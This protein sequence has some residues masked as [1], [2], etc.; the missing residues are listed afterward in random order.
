MSTPTGFSDSEWPLSD[1]DTSSFASLE[2]LS[3]PEE[4]TGDDSSYVESSKKRKRATTP[5]DLAQDGHA[6][7]KKLRQTKARQ[8]P[9]IPRRQD[10]FFGHLN[11]NIRDRIYAHLVFDPLERPHRTPVCIDGHAFAKT[12][13][14]ARKEL[15]EEAD[16]Q[17][18]AFLKC[19]SDVYKQ[20]TE[21]EIRFSKELADR[22][23]LTGVKD[24][25]LICTGDIPQFAPHNNRMPK[26]FNRLLR[27]HLRSLTLHFVGNSKQNG[28]M[29]IETLQ[30]FMT[31]A[32]DRMVEDNVSGL[33]PHKPPFRS[34][35]Q[36]PYS[37]LGLSPGPTRPRHNYRQACWIQAVGKSQAPD[38]GVT[39]K[40]SRW[41]RVQRRSN[42]RESLIDV[43]RCCKLRA[44]RKLLRYHLPRAFSEGGSVQYGRVVTGTASELEIIE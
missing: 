16:H 5:E 43:G 20:D 33:G 13:R 31:N 29:D 21:H 9:G 42:C 1:S 34:P 35:Y 2:W 10:P 40:C 32:L 12:C 26:P 23:T 22:A 30:T 27:L 38:C 4:D 7:W 24:L 17:L 3:D 15:R 39:D 25:T 8:Q 19:A 28:P 37:L 14:Q 11:R 36:A 41:C 44:A 6:Q 18:R